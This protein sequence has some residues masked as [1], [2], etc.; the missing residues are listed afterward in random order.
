MFLSLSL[1]TME[2]IVLPEIRNGMFSP[3]EFL[4]VLWRGSEIYPLGVSFE[5]ASYC[6]WCAEDDLEYGQRTC[7]QRFYAAG[8]FDHEFIRDSLNGWYLTWDGS[9]SKPSVST[10]YEGVK[11]T[12]TIR[13]G[14]LVFSQRCCTLSFLPT[15]GDSFF[16]TGELGAWADDRSD[17]V[18]HTFDNDPG[19][20]VDIPLVLFF[21]VGMFPLQNLMEEREKEIPVC[22]FFML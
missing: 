5:C 9:D 4:S 17:F 22:C 12:I 16:S 10:R 15:G 13:D 3:W 1:A 21:F 2:P 20:Q 11:R 7:S 8:L 14:E 6:L 19:M 18:T